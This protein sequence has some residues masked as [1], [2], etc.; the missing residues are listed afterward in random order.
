MANFH[1]NLTNITAALTESLLAVIRNAKLDELLAESGPTETERGR[2]TNREAPKVKTRST[3]TPK[4][5]SGRLPRRSDTE[6]VAAL[7]QVIALVKKNREGLRAEAIRE[8]LGLQSKELPRILKQGLSTRRL[9][10]KGQKRATT[11]FAA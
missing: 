3:P 5:K 2:R 6:I 7:D 9:K 11:Y 10:S 1:S 4:A 8:E